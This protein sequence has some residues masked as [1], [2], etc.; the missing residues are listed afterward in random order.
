MIKKLHP[1]IFTSFLFLVIS[2]AL[3]GRESFYMSV[4]QN[5]IYMLDGFEKTVRVFDASASQTGLINLKNIDPSGFFDSF[6]R[7]DG[8]KSYAADSF[9]NTIYL[10]DENFALKA[11]SDIFAAHK[12]K[13]SGMIYPVRYNAVIAASSDNDKLFSLENNVLKLI[14][15]LPYRFTDWFADTDAIYI[16]SGTDI[17]VYSSEGSLRTKLNCGNEFRF[18]KITASKETVFL[19]SDQGIHSLSLDGSERSFIPASNVLCFA[20]LGSIVYYYDGKDLKLTGT[21]E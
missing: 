18:K 4:F 8:L 19:L 13:I 7:Y 9:R 15:S 21:N 10:L 16:L 12:E 11:K 1:Q 5:N 2:V 3:T 17:S 14:I 6:V 20:S